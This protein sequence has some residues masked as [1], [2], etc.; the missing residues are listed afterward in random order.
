MKT[1]Q[2]ETKNPHVHL[3]EPDVERDAVL[4]VTWLEGEM[5]RRTLTLMG[6]ADKDNKP[7]S[8]VEER[9]RVNGFITK[10]DELNWMIAYDG[11]V[12]GTIWVDLEASEHVRGPSVHIMIGDPDMRGKGVGSTSMR[13]VMDYLHSQGTD[14][15]YSRH[16]VENPGSINLLKDLG[17]TEDGQPYP[18]KDGL[19]WQNV[20][21]TPTP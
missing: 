5:G 1:I 11:K 7:T 16:I 13:S 10:P 21:Y 3:V 12:V 2:L 15:I 20:S 14:T 18:D 6:V 4:G 17:F 9:E 19:H 8:L